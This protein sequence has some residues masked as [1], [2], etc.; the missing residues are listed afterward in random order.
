MGNAIAKRLQWYGN[1]LR[2]MSAREVA[3][4]L[5]Q[6]LLQKREQKACSP[7]QQVCSST[8]YHRAFSHC[9][10]PSSFPHTPAEAVDGGGIAAPG[11]QQAFG[12][13][14]WPEC[15]DG[16]CPTR[17]CT[18]SN[19]FATPLPNWSAGVQTAHDWPQE[20]A[21]TLTYKQRD[22]IGD[23]RTNWEIN[24]HFTWPRMALDYATTANPA[25][26]RRLT[27][28]FNDY[29]TR[30][31]FLYGISWTSVME[32]AIRA[33]QWLLTASILREA[34]AGEGVP[35]QSLSAETARLTARLEIGAV[36]MI[37]HCEIHRSRHSSANNHLL[38]EMCAVGL[39]GLYFGNEAWTVKAIEILTREL[40]LQNSPEGVNLE[41]SLHY[42]GF[43]MEAYLLMMR[44]MRRGGMEV[45]QSWRD[46]MV[47]MG[48]FVA[49]SMA[50]PDT[51]MEFGDEDAGKIIDLAP[52]G[53]SYYRY[54]L[55]MA[56][57]ETAV[58]LAD[59]HRVEPTVERLYS[60]A[61]L[62]PY[63]L[64]CYLTP[65]CRNF[66]SYTFL[67]DNDRRTLVG[68]DHAPLGFGAIAA[69]GHADMMSF[70]LYRDGRPVFTDG[71]T[72][73]Y[74]CSLPDR[75]MRRSELMHNTINHAGHPQAEML[76]AFLW[77]KRG[78]V[79]GTVRQ[80]NCDAVTVDMAG[81]TFDGT[82]MARTIE[83]SKTDGALTVT[84]R[85]LSEADTASYII[86]PGI[87]VELHGNTALIGNLY[88]L[89]TDGGTLTAEEVTVA[90]HYGALLPA[91][92]LRISGLKG[93]NRV[94][95]TPA[96]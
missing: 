63:R 69:H 32:A 59:F 79:E 96:K 94:T 55:Q 56:T 64:L 36:N 6:K 18:T 5:N 47:K 88:I 50:A 30:Q 48:E 15:I 78:H 28:E 52:E 76:G 68:I 71:G 39:G 81:R 10:L 13:I 58:P 92:A 31:P 95:I 74:H 27:D 44:A 66:G 8:A 24:R 89:T 85:H 16:T 73:L 62:E 86:A 82:P 60:A 22:E 23:A 21:Y 45:P 83:F 49:C 26:L 11:A 46:M 14:L 40:P 51:A 91:T 84:D 1:R 17:T 20:W 61:E 65:S 34:S 38:V 4:R 53:H 90:P 25:F 87:D 29:C 35:P 80:P 37:T 42:H 7:G 12:V 57:V 54:L 75:N 2:A 67:R 41:M 43:V 77:G 19:P 70:Q 72:Y 33:V 9:P 93:T 3:W